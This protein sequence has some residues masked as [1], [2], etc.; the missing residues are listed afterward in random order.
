MSTVKA[1]LFKHAEQVFALIILLNAPL[2]NFLIPYKLVFM[3]S[4]FI[5]ILLGTYYLGT[6]TA[7]MGGVLSTLLITIYV[8]YFPDRFQGDLSELSLWMRL[9]AWSGFL[10]LT[11]AVTGKAIDRLRKK[12]QILEHTEKELRDYAHRMELLVTDL[13]RSETESQTAD[14]EGTP[15]IRDSDPRGPALSPATL[16]DQNI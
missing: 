16:P 7:L 1:Y 6:R 9:L 14:S 8:Y 4:Y 11:A 15:Y 2:L 13:T 12:I 5:L 10:I 3:N